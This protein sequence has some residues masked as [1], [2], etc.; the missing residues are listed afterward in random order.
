[1][2]NGNDKKIDHDHEKA[3]KPKT[4]MIPSMTITIKNKSLTN[5]K[6]TKQIRNK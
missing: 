1:M 6:K 2:D 5:K 4:I 3:R